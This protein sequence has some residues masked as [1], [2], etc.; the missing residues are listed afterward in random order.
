M[1]E[2]I[3]SNWATILIVILFFAY[4][5]F[6]VITKQWT[7]LREAAYKIMLAAEKVYLTGQGRKKFN[8]V[9][10][11]V[12]NLVPAWLKL[13]VSEYWLRCKLQEWYNLVK[14]YADDGK[15]DSNKKGW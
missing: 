3:F 11:K 10:V 12:Y 14:D 7:K 15:I 8:Y 1:K 9:F 6:L 13:F 5:L 4:I 2:F